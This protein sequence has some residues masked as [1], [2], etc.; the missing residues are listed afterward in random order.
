MFP[1]S[2]NC[3]YSQSTKSVFTKKSQMDGSNFILFACAFL[4]PNRFH[5]TDK[6]SLA[7][8]N[9]E[10]TIENNNYQ[11]AWKIVFLHKVTSAEIA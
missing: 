7:F 5:A 9:S 4:L 11:N 6:A 2:G 10:K 3:I 8:S 1:A